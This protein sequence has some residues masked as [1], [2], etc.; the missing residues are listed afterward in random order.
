MPRFAANLGMLFSDRPLIARFAAAAAVGFPAVEMQVPYELGAPAAKAEIARHG[1]VMLGIN[2][3]P[4]HP[5]EF[6]LAAVPGREKAF[7]AG[8]RQALDYA[9][10]I[11]ATA[12]HCMAGVVPP[13]QRLAAEAVFVRNLRHAADLAMES[14][15][16]LLI[17]PLNHRDRPD[18]FLTRVEHAADVISKVG[19]L[20]VR[21]QFDCYHVQVMQG[22]LIRRLEQHLGLLGHVQIAGVPGREEPDQ[23]EVNY[24]AIYT[25]LDRMGYRG[26]IAAEY[27]PRGR[28]EDALD[29]AAP[30]G[31]GPGQTGS[32]PVGH[33]P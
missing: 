33:L 1:L 32:Q 31:I 7:D 28:T 11:G 10:T 6:G 15:V 30:F 2:T 20:N 3:P 14:G 17:E 25:A 24:P 8:F 9:G 19:R 16:T 23:G 5:G 18:Y 13:E 26:W 4:G 22:D 27:R 21:I 29:W 12:I